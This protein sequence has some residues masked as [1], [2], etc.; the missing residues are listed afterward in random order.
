MNKVQRKVEYAL[1]ALKY[2]ASKK[3]GEVTTAKEVAERFQSSFD[4]IAR[5]LQTLVANE[6][7]HSTQGVNGGYLLAKDLSQISLLD[8]ME[9]LSGPTAIAKCLS[10]DETCDLQTTCNI[11][12]PIQELNHQLSSFYKGLK[13]NTLL[14]EKESSHV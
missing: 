10:T 4:M 12:S 6:W 7:L 13:L 14:V 1:M 11:S 3:Q 8:L 2:I 5:V 9:A